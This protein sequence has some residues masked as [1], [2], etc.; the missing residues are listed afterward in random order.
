MITKDGLL[1]MAAQA[2]R[3]MEAN[4][5]PPGTMQTDTWRQAYNR[6]EAALNA[7]RWLEEMGLTERAQVGPFGNI[8]VQKGDQVRIKAG[9]IIRT[10]HPRYDRNNPKIAKRAY[11]V[12][13]YDVHGG[14]INTHW[15]RHQV[16]WAARDQE[17]TWPGEGGYWCYASTQDIEIV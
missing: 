12:T 2:D 17:I 15:H 4:K 11:K 16:E 1:E 13:V 5:L 3:D 8:R 14:S 6:R 10:T 9:T 7:A